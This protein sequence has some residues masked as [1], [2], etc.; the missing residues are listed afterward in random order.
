MEANQTQSPQEHSPN[1]ASP[2]QTMSSQNFSR[3]PKRKKISTANIIVFF[4]LLVI[5]GIIAL[6]FF[7]D[8]SK[9]G[10]CTTADD[11]GIYNIF[12]ISGDGY[13]C[14]SKGMAESSSFKSKVL[15]FKYASKKAIES[16]PKNCLCSSAQCEIDLD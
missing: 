2:M 14:A 6:F 11:C 9:V 8:E 3:E 7:S 15:M 13:V 16:E 12:Y 5:L 10:N 4:I 1:P